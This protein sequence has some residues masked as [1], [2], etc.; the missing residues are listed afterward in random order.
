[1]SNPRSCEDI[2]SYYNVPKIG[3]IGR[4]YKFSSLLEPVLYLNLGLNFYSSDDS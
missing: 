3:L 1:M 4:R 2:N